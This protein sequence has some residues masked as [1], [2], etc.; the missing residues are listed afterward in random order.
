MLTGRI[1]LLFVLGGPLVMAA[2]SRNVV[3]NNQ[4]GVPTFKTGT[5]LVTLD[6]VV[7][8]GKGDPISGLKQEGFEVLENGRPQSIATFEEHSGSAISPIDLP[9]MPPNVYTNF[10]AVNRRQRS[11]CS[12]LIR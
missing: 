2:Q 7:T 10:L 9:P 3:P 12:C 4:A 5:R 8:N 6:I 11:T 1:A